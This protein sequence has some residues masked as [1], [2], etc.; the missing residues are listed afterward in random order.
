VHVDICFEVN[1]DTTVAIEV[2]CPKKCVAGGTG[3]D[4][5]SIE[6]PTGFSGIT[7]N[8]WGRR[9]RVINFNR[10][11]Q[12]GSFIRIL[13]CSNGA[14]TSGADCGLGVEDTTPGAIPFPDAPKLLKFVVDGL[15]IN[16]YL[17][18][19]LQNAEDHIDGCVY[20]GCRVRDEATGCC[21]T[22]VDGL[23]ANL[24]QIPWGSEILVG[25][26]GERTWP[27]VQSILA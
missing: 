27:F 19:V 3:T 4:P 14:C 15:N 16:G 1:A 2:S 26:L 17:D 12:S 11:V 22:G 21:T 5:Y 18:S 8:S 13:T 7:E 20:V 25:P 9:T 23:F 10:F 6:Y 24:D